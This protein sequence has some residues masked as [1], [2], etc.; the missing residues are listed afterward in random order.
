MP[1]SDFSSC[2][3]TCISA[4]ILIC[5]A[6]VTSIDDKGNRILICNPH[7]AS[8]FPFFFII[9]ETTTC[10]LLNY[11]MNNLTNFQIP[12]VW[13]VKDVVNKL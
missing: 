6:D 13:E 2:N 7:K 5:F 4:Y 1:I 9:I 8:I 11:P 10:F 12:D 3:I